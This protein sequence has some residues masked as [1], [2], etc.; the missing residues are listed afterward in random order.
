MTLAPAL[1]SGASAGVG[2][3]GV[4]DF[5]TFGWIGM[6][7]N[8]VIMIGLIVGV[9]LLIAWLVKRVDASGQAAKTTLGASPREV[10][11]LRYPLCHNE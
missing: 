7:L 11:Q 9:V 4:G 2:G 8:W 1:R 10:L 3:F 5:G 6:I